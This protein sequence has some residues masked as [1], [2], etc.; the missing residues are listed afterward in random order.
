MQRPSNGWSGSFAVLQPFEHGDPL[1]V[2][3]RVVERT[4]VLQARDA[5]RLYEE[6]FRRTEDA[7]VD[8]RPAI[9]LGQTQH[10]GITELLQPA[11]LAFGSVLAV[12]AKT[13]PTH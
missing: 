13:P 12:L 7:P 5:P 10:V 8:R 4:D 6:G 11:P 9:A 2:D 3:A 1:V